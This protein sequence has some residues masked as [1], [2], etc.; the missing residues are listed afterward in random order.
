MPPWHMRHSRTIVY[1]A[2]AAAMI[3]VAVVAW[4]DSPE[5]GV[6]LVTARQ[7]LGLWA[8]GLVLASL[9]VGPLTAVLPWFPLRPTLMYARR[10]VGV[11]ALYFALAHV[12]CY[13]WS[14][15]RRDWRE[16]YTPGWMWV[17]GLALGVL[18]MADLIALGWTSRDASVKKLGGRRWKRLHSTLYVT[19]FVLLAHALLVGADFGINRG[20]DVRAEADFG[21]GIAFACLAV[22]WVALYLLRRGNVRWRPAFVARWRG[23]H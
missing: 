6:R 20:P 2:G 1:A 21:A 19:L 18:A 9:L 17:A 23:V 3:A 13:L 7:L 22:A 5:W 8:L 10:A 4:T 14:V 12:G 16:L 15:G 11:T